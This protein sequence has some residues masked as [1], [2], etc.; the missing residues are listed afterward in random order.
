[1]RWIL[2]ALAISPLNVL[3]AGAT[4]EIVSDQ[5]RLTLSQSQLLSRRDLRTIS[6]ADSDYKARLTRFK[7]IP[8]ANLFRGVVI[9]DAAVV[10]F[11]ATDGFAASLEK[12][13]LFSTDPKAAKAF[14]AIEDPRSPWPRLPGKTVS[15]GPFYLVWTNPRASA[16]S[17]EEWPYQIASFTILTDPRS[18]FP[19]IYPAADAAPALQNGFRSFQRNCF[20]CHKMNGDGAGAIGPDLN[21]PMNPVEYL[22]ASAL[23]SL[24]RDPT[25][26]RT[27]PQRAM[28]GFPE[29]AISDSE[30]ADLMAYLAH[31]SSRK[32]RASP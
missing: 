15:A 10:Q 11:R 19:R 4:L 28:V 3:A 7:A 16:V 12:T 8:I 27:W 31:M 25:S 23:K 13:R 30:L 21:L 26:V 5:Q 9:P 20:P 2:L 1:M 17:T 29:S 18:V 6:V 32:S 22:N 24:I 14:L